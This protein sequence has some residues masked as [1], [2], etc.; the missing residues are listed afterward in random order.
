MSTHTTQSAKPAL[1]VAALSPLAGVA[2]L[3]L[4]GA[5]ALPT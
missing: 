5:G 4:A 1:I 2:A 3:L